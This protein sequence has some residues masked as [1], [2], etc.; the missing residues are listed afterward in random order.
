[1][2]EENLPGPGLA[3]SDKAAQRGGRLRSEQ[4]CSGL[5]RHA[6]RQECG[7][8][9]PAPRGTLR[10]PAP[11]RDQPGKAPDSLAGTILRNTKDLFEETISGNVD[12]GLEPEQRALF[13]ELIRDVRPTSNV[14]EYV[15]AIRAGE[16]PV[17]EDPELQAVTIFEEL[18]SQE[19]AQ[20][21]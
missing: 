17:I 11:P 21:R 2:A 5:Y 16:A 15:L 19:R 20:L 13:Q 8:E 12:D 7:C 18:P 1:M 6:S 3:I 10:P 14:P 4:R 9:L